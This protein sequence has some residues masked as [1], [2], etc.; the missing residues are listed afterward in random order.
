M[1]SVTLVQ[2]GAWLRAKMG[3]QKTSVE[4]VRVV[5]KISRTTI[6][7]LLNGKHPPSVDT[8]LGISKALRIERGWYDRLLANEEPA[9]L[10]VNSLDDVSPELQEW[11]AELAGEVDGL[12]ADLEAL[13]QDH[14]GLQAAVGDLRRQL[15]ALRTL[16]EVGR[17]GRESV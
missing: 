2:V 4:H 16:V 9:E 11:R 14:L 10:E 8:Q 5:G 15:E 3:A 7:D 1:P 17:S 12:A 13:R 6:Y